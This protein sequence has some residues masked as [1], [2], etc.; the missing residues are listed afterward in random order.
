[1]N[2][3]RPGLNKM[4]AGKTVVVG[5]TGGIA[6]YK[7]AEL[8]S[9]LRKAGAAVHVVMTE[10]ACNFVTPL[11]F[12]SLSANPVHVGMFGAAKL[13]GIDH[14]ELAR[15]ADL[16]VVAP[17]TANIIAKAAN[18][19][20]DD[21]LSAILLAR[22]GPI[23]LAP[24]MNDQMYLHPATQANLRKLQDFGYR[25]AEPGVGFQACG[26]EGPGRMAEPADI[27]AQCKGLLAGYGPLNG[28]TILITAGGTREAIDPVRYIGNRSSGKMGYALARAAK[29]A[30]GKVILVSAPTGLQVPAG[31]EYIGVESAAEMRQAVLAHFPES[32]I[33]IKAAAVADYR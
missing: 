19:L 3:P 29:E 5:V 16:L 7:S 20:A 8:V 2:A 4:L 18:G 15:K 30:G 33:V 26:T 25:F 11:T 12:Q 10:N 22:R 14:I 1:M 6:A 13:G 24:A 31:V 28:K 9:R 21:L 17:A 23:L 27:F 32:D